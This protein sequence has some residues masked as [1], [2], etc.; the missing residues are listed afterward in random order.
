[1]G[2]AQ[3]NSEV[4]IKSKHD[5]LMPPR[6]NDTGVMNERNPGILRAIDNLCVIRNIIFVTR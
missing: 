3:Y 4:R 5:G 1:M 6:H 2:I